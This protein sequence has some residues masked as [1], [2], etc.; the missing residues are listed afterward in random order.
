MKRTKSELFFSIVWSRFEPAGSA[1]LGW[2]AGHD[3]SYMR[4]KPS[5]PSLGLKLRRKNYVKVIHTEIAQIIALQTTI[6]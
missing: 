4:F 2:V 6:E 1:H 5:Q 3:P